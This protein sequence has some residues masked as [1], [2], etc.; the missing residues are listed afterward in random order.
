MLTAKPSFSLKAQITMPGDKS[1]SH[2]AILLGSL[3]LGTTV[4]NNFLRSDDCLRTIQAMQ[5]L[6]VPIHIACDNQIEIQGVAI[7][8]L[9]TPSQPIDC[10]N[11]GTLMR[12]LSGV[13]A[14]TSFETHLTGDA[15]LCNRPMDRIVEPLQKMGASIT[16]VKKNGCVTPPLIIKGNP[17]L[18]SIDYKLAVPSAQ[19]KSCLLMAGLFAQGKTKVHEPE[20]SRDHTERLF[21]VFGGSITREDN[22][23]GI[24]PQVLQGAS[25]TIPGDISSAA[26]FI[27][28]ATLIPN[29]HLVIKDVGLNPTRMGLLHILRLMGANIQ[30]RIKEGF[31]PC[32]EITIRSSNLQGIEVPASLIVAA[33]DEFPALFIAS[34]FAKGET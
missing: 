25:L 20:K 7:H 34:A 10:G 16:G 26:F 31:E 13:L 1:I 28:A 14:A 21:P 12:I 9:K 8:N 32:G 29:S 2:R 19:V 11:S 3:S 18:Q 4:I 17:C 33:I 15:S 22:V 24:T 5:N 30:T 27:V 6:G 23:I